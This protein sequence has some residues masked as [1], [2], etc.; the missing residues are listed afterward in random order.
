MHKHKPMFFVFA[1][2]NGS[3]K[4]AFRNLIIDKIGLR[5]QY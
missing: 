1:G 5:D 2:N 4:S 3:R